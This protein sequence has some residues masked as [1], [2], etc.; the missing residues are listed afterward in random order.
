MRMVCPQHAASVLCWPHTRDACASALGCRTRR[1]R[2]RVAHDARVR[3]DSARARHTCVGNRRGGE[4]V[5]DTVDEAPRGGATPMHRHALA[6]ARRAVHPSR[7]CPLLHGA[8][9]AGKPVSRSSAPDSRPGARP[10]KAA[11]RHRN[12]GHRRCRSVGSRPCRCRADFRAGRGLASNF[13]R[14]TVRR[15]ELRGRGHRRGARGRHGGRGRGQGGAAKEGDHRDACVVSL[16]SICHVDLPRA[17]LS[18]SASIKH[19][20]DECL[21]VCTICLCNRRSACNRHGSSISP[22]LFDQYRR[23]KQDVSA[24]DAVPAPDSLSGS[25]TVTVVDIDQNF[26]KW[27]VF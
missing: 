22:R 16:L 9:G 26:D 10:Y 21:R 23:H 6:M 5:C 20:A 18:L 24:T 8:A 12:R 2:R 13:W 27:P 15:R 14:P 11:A 17:L 3:R 1:E 4:R 19:G 25:G 7:A